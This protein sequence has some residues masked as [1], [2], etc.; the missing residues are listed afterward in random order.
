MS[1]GFRNRLLGEFGEVSAASIEN[2][3][4]DEGPMSFL[5]SLGGE[6]VA[7]PLTVREKV[8]SQGEYAGRSRLDYQSS[9]LSAAD[10]TE[11]LADPGALD[12]DN[13]PL[14]EAEENRLA[15]L[16]VELQAMDPDLARFNKVVDLTNGGET[17]G[18]V[19]FVYDH[20]PA[21]KA[22]IEVGD[23]LVR[24]HIKGQPRPLEVQ[25][26]P[27]DMGW[28]A[29]YL[30]ALD[31]IDPSYYDQ[32][33]PPWGGAETTLTRSLTDVGFGTPFTAEVFRGGAILRL[34]F[35][36]EEG[37][38]HY[39]AAAKFKSEAAGLTVKDLTYEARRFFQLTPEDAGV[40]VSNIEQG[41]GAAVA[42]IKPFE[43]IVAV[44]DA[45]VHSVGDFEAAIAGGGELRF[46][47]MRMHMGRLVKIR[48]P[49]GE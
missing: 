6:L 22:G 7:L 20:S 38:A 34:E 30:E 1:R 43:L 28:G 4:G 15:W 39:G 11:I 48:V 18:I 21:A 37:P 31:Q 33:P 40:I 12:P 25:V 26:S 16:G 13:R 9:V 47:I 10:L 44:N 27:Y 24:L 32:I 5:F 8:A 19:T 2:G 45:P 17:G 36:V 14:S 29:Q 35:A 41:E 42:G 46:S 3:D 23:I 49:E